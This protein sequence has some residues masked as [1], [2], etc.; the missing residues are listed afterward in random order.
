MLTIFALFL[1]LLSALASAD[2][3]AL[4][5]FAADWRDNPAGPANMSFLLDAP[6]GRDGPITVRDG[7]MVTPDG[8]RFRIWGVNVTGSACFPTKEDA[9]AVAD[10]LARYA[11]NCVRFHFLDSNWSASLFVRGADNT[12]TLNAAQLDRFDFFVAE[13]KKRG[14]YTNINLNVGRNY[15]QADGVIDY[16]KM[17]LAKVLN[18]FDDRIQSLHREYAQQL[19]T[20]RNPYMQSEY[21]NEPAVC[22]VELVNENSLVEA[23]FSDRLLGAHTGRPAGTWQDITPHYAELLTKKY[24]AW[25][26][27]NLSDADLRQLHELTNTKPGDLIPRLTYKQFAKAPE[28]QFHAEAAFYMHCEDAYFQM[29]Y[30][31]LKDDLKVNAL[32]VANSDHNHYRS[33]YALLSSMSKLDVVDGHVYWQHPN[34]IIDPQ[35]GKR[36]FR[37]PNTP[38]VKDPFNSTVVQLSRSAVAGKPYTVSETNHPFPHQYACEGIPILAA[39]AAFHDWD[40]LFF[41]TFEHADPAD[42]LKRTPGHFD[43]R[44]DPV[45]MTN[46]AACAP[47]FLRADVKP[48]NETLARSYAPHQIIES[49]RASSSLRPYFTPGFNSA[50]ALTYGMRINSFTRPTGPLPEMEQSSP[51]V[52]DTAQLAWHHPPQSKGLVTVDTERSQAL[53][54]FV[55]DNPRTLANLSAKVENDFCSIVLTSL[56]AN[57]IAQS[58]KLL[59][60]AT[61]RAQTTDMKY[62]EDKTSL[63]SW[64]KPPMQIEPVTGHVTLINIAA[65]QSVSITPLDPTGRPAAKPAAATKKA[66]SYEMPL[67]AQ[68][69]TW[70]L[71]E[72]DR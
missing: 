11:V 37:M 66:S 54:G 64:G 2:N 62:N 63:E 49:L 19:L 31:H 42:W 70:Y 23:W 72:I 43:V 65:A 16:D 21:R 34:E 58:K 57:P 20:H 61:A 40:G 71:I 28:K 59:L 9:P 3:P 68:P 12:R 45:K 1:A 41:Y 69:T 13:L 17:G 4:S 36:T 47:L 15:R 56:D 35:T 53:I 44:P 52:C 67:G 60:A 22:I 51:V 5:P 8:S 25:L 38:M 14:I 7:H 18:Y 27:E 46:L 10:H 32:I 30:R 50:L 55:K 26:K 33:G 48:A 6:A 24:N 29:M 39:Y